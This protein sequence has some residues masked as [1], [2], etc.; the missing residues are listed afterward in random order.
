MSDKYKIN[1]GNEAYFVTFIQLAR[2]PRRVSP[3]LT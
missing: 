1:K 3:N 2:V